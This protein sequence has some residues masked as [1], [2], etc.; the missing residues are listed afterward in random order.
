[1]A[2]KKITPSDAPKKKPEHKHPH[3]HLLAGS[4]LMQNLKHR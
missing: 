3:G 4:P 2:K 1:M